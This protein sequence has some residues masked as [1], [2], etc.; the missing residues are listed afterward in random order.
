M[1]VGEQLITLSSKSIA[2][3][4]RFLAYMKMLMR[5][6]WSSTFF[7]PSALLHYHRLS[8]DSLQQSLT[9]ALSQTRENPQGLLPQMT[10][11]NTAPHS[12]FLLAI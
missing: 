10:L 3:T 7:A 12:L 2:Q 1:S 6:S 11:D 8:N 5:G 4:Q 9:A